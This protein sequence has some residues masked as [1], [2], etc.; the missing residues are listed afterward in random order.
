VERAILHA[1][2]MHPSERPESVSAFHEELFASRPLGSIVNDSVV[3]AARRWG[4][5]VRDNAWLL[6]LTLI[7]LVIALIATAWSPYLP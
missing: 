1:M 7:L 5:A 6:L 3:R 4:S 2:A